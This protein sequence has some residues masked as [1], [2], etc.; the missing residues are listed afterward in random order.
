MLLDCGYCSRNSGP[1][2]PF[3][4][5]FPLPCF[6]SYPQSC[7]L[8]YTTLHQALRPHQP[9]QQLQTST[10]IIPNHHQAILPLLHHSF[11]RPILPPPA[12]I[13]CSNPRPYPCK[14]S[15]APPPPKIRNPYSNI[16]KRTPPTLPT[17]SPQTN[18]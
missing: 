8:L 9:K 6:V 5:L 1:F 17:Q 11:P 18:L 15:P 12:L 13:P 3:L 14:P 2:R 7:L 4:F 10:S 16:K